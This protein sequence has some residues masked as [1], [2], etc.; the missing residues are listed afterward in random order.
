M[1]YMFPLRKNDP[2][3]TAQ[4]KLNKYNSYKEALSKD[5]FCCCGYCG[6]HHVYYGSGK[7]FHIDHFAPKSKFKH[8]E[9]E[10]SNLV[11]SCPTC[12]IAKSN[13]WCGNNEN[14][15][16]SNGIGYIEPCDTQ[17]SEAFYRDSSGK[18]RYKEGNSA[19]KYMYDKLKFGLRRHEI[20]WLA[21]YFYE[22]V[23]RI[24]RKLKETP[25][26]NPLH[27]ELKSLLLDVIDQMDKYRQLQ[28]EL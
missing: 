18:I 5:F 13:D 17:Y 6:A 1:L 24:S 10:Y 16:I 8:L 20:F 2:K 27:V 7:C 11:Y 15:S 28:R 9:N 19:A 14:E 23:P 3:R 12:N 26:N 25:E 4:K 21:D 22:L